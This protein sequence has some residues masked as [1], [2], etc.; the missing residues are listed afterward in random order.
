MA[1]TFWLGH[2]G[3][4]K[5]T[6]PWKLRPQS[7]AIVVPVLPFV[8]SLY[9]SLSCVQNVPGVFPCCQKFLYQ[10]R[11]DI[12][13]WV[14]PNIREA[15]ACTP[16]AAIVRH[17][18]SW[19]TTWVWSWAMGFF[20]V[21]KVKTPSPAHC[22]AFFMMG[23]PTARSEAPPT[24]PT[25]RLRH[26]RDLGHCSVGNASKKGTHSQDAHLHANLM[27][28][29]TLW[30]QIYALNIYIYVSTLHSVYIKQATTQSFQINVLILGRPTC[31]LHFLGPNRL[32]YTLRHVTNSIM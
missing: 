5:S 19:P 25:A 23:P 24:T 8:F 17:S 21:S 10:L 11:S 18:P 7:K 16:T 26:A 2:V 20:P 3:P 6:M 12:K 14:K 1:G 32:N 13:K 9:P 30:L 31:S 29:A 15:R 22:I 4:A 28:D 27:T